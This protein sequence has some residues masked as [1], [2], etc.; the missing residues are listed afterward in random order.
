MSAGHRRQ[1]NAVSAL[2]TTA[3]ARFWR[4]T[5]RHRFFLPLAA[6]LVANLWS[7]PPAAAQSAPGCPP[8]QA[9]AFVLGFATLAQQLGATMGTPLECEHVDPRSGDTVQRT[10][11]GLGYYRP[12][13]G[14]VTFTNG[15]EHWAL[16]GGRLLY[17]QGASVDPPSPTA[18]ESTYL[19]AV[20]PLLRETDGVLQALNEAALAASQGQTLD[21]QFA[22]AGEQLD[23]INAAQATFDALAAPPALAPYAD[24]VRQ[25]QAAV[26]SAAEALLR[27]G[28]AEDDPGYS[29]RVAAFVAWVREANRR[30][31]A[32]DDS[33]A[34]AV[35]VA[36]P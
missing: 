35:P 18:E 9:P 25:T 19:D 23:R 4:F 24:T 21:I 30:R 11:T 5:G 16:V 14:A 12:T 3:L 27:V 31:A 7:A 2:R 22:K 15:S 17:W 32:V 10:T 33:R 26:Q 20:A 8:G 29:M 6:A 28:L 13:T 36:I 1:E 34:D